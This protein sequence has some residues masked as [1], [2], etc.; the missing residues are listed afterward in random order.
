M[1]EMIGWELQYMAVVITVGVFLSFVYDCFRIIRRLVRHGTVWIAIEDILFW[2]FAS[3][4]TFAVC[5]ME[6]AGNVRWF[7]IVGEILGALMYHAT[8]SRFLVKYVSLVLFF[9]LKVLK[10]IVKSFKIKEVLK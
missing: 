6:D 4:V 5:F 10:K 7:A 8:I 3:I 9:P 1:S 2:M